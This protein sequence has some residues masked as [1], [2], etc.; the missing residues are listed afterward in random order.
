MKKFLTLLLALTLCFSVVGCSKPAE[1]APTEGG[2]Y[3]AGTYTGVSENG[4]GGTVKVEVVFTDNEITSVTVTEHSETAGISD[5]AIEQIP[6]G[7]VE[8]QSLALDAITGVTV[9]SEAILEAVADAV[10]QAGGDPEALMKEIEKAVST[11]VVE[12]ETDV[13]VV[14]GG[15]AGMAA[16]LRLTELGKKVVLLEKAASLGG[17][18]GVSGGNQVVSGSKL[19]AEAGVTNDTAQSMYDDFMKNGANLNVPE[20]LT[21]YAENVGPTTDWLNET[22]GIEYDMEGG[23]HKLGE[24]SIDR[25]LAYVG[26]GNGFATTARTAIENCGADVYINTKAES[27]MVEDG[28]VTGV[29]AVNADGTTYNIKSSAVVLATGGYGNNKD[30]LTDEMKSALYY[31][32]STSTGDGILMAQEAV[33]ADTRLMEYGKRYPNGVE[34]SEGI[35]K[36]T[37]AGNIV[38]WTMSAILVNPEGERVVNEKASNR[39]IL[40]VELQQTNG[41]LYLLL[42]KE[43]F[44]VWKTKLAGAGLSEGDIDKYVENNGAST[45]V[46]ATGETLADVA[47][48]VGMDGATLEATVEKYNGFV[49]AGKD[50]DFGRDPQFMTMKVGEGPYYLI[51]QKPRF[52]TTMG[53]LVV[54]TNLQVLNKAGEVVEGLYAAGETVGGVMGDDSPSGANNGWAL[55]AGKLAAEA[56]CA[57]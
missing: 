22:V 43:T 26:G 25:E 2:M 19:Q 12:L 46:F 38:G 1:Q 37:I 16:T 5:P 32:P 18:I 33:D 40:E 11:E 35:A 47:K 42:D 36:S 50:D 13:V 7:I 30:M 53:G 15:A 41:M 29:V 44:D 24:Y 8:N 6:A 4:K 54:N 52:A 48:V 20:L 56:I 57:E 9:T 3:K 17:A 23:L 55:T 28:K 34:V 51:E 31:G 10:K 45:P 39:T 14:G 27:L 21:L 49:E